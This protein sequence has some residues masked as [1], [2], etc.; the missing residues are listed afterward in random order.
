MRKIWG[1]FRKFVKLL[2]KNLKIF[3]KNIEM[4]K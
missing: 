4:L 3:D 1:I 2:W